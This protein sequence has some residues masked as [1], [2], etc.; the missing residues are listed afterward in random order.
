MSPA[1]INAECR[2]KNTTKTEHVCL[3]TN[4]QPGGYMYQKSHWKR[5]FVS[6][7]I[8]YSFQK[9]QTF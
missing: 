7:W 5:M 2:F 3:K 6:W 1:I 4:D 8:L 9:E